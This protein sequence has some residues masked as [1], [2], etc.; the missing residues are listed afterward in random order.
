M[1]MLSISYIITDTDPLV[2]IK[3]VG[4]VYSVADSYR[5]LFS[6]AVF[7]HNSFFVEKTLYE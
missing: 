3:N 4:F 5:I 6:N 7:D 1:I 2:G